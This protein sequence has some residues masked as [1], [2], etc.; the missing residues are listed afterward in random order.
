[1]D[2][3]SCE[4]G[5]TQLQRFKRDVRNL[6][7]TFIAQRRRGARDLRHVVAQPRM[8]LD[9]GEHIRLRWLSID[10][11]AVTREQSRFV[12]EEPE[13]RAAVDESV[14]ARRQDGATVADV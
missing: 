12:D 3:T 6:A 9:A 2:S 10:Q 1:M 5:D 4:A 7:A 13:P 11:V 14:A 8:L